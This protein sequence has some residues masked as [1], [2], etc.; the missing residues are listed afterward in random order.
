MRLRAQLWYAGLLFVSLFLITNISLSI[1]THHASANNVA[2]PVAHEVESFSSK[3]DVADAAQHPGVKRLSFL[4]LPSATIGTDVPRK[5]SQQ[6][7]PCSSHNDSYRVLVT[8]LSRSGST[9]QYN[10]IKTILNFELGAVTAVHSDA[11]SLEFEKCLSEQVCVLKTHVFTPRLLP[12]VDF[13][14]TSHRDLRDVLLSSMQMF[15]SCLGTTGLLRSREGSARAHDV[16]Q[17]FQQY[18]HWIP[19]ACYD[20]S[21]ET[22]YADRAAEIVR[23]AAVLGFQRD[24]EYA[25]KVVREIDAAASTATAKKGW[26]AESGFSA[27]HVHQSTTM[28]GAH[29]SSNVLVQVALQLPTCSLG[30]AFRHIEIGFGKWQAEHGYYEDTVTTNA[31]VETLPEYGA[32]HGPR[33]VWPRL[34]HVHF[35]SKGAASSSINLF[36]QAAASAEKSEFIQVSVIHASSCSGSDVVSL[37]DALACAGSPPDYVVVTSDFIGAPRPRLY[38]RIRQILADVRLSP[39]KAFSLP[40][41][42]GTFGDDVWRH[43]ALLLPRRWSSH[44]PFKKVRVGATGWGVGVLTHVQESLGVALVVVDE[45]PFFLN[46]VRGG[47]ELRKKGSSLADLRFQ[48]ELS[49]REDESPFGRCCCHAPV[50]SMRPARWPTQSSAMTSTSRHY[51]YEWLQGVPKE[52]ASHRDIALTRCASLLQSDFFASTSQLRATVDMWCEQVALDQL[53][54]EQLAAHKRRTSTNQENRLLSDAC[55]RESLF[56]GVTPRRIQGVKSGINASSVWGLAEEVETARLPLR[57]VVVR[58]TMLHDSQTAIF[59]GA[60]IRSLQLLDWLCGLGHSVTLV[61]RDGGSTSRSPL[62]KCVVAVKKDA[63]DMR[64]I[65]NGLEETDILVLEVA[66]S[67]RSKILR[68]PSVYAVLER[69]AARGKK[70]HNLRVVVVSYDLHYHAFASDGSSSVRTA[71]ALYAFERQ[72]YASPYVDFVVAASLED[73][74]AFRDLQQLVG[75]VSPGKLPPVVVIPILAKIHSTELVAGH[76]VGAHVASYDKRDTVVFFVESSSS[77][78]AINHIF[79]LWRQRPRQARLVMLKSPSSLSSNWAAPPP[80][81]VDVVSCQ[82]RE[83]IANALRRARLVILVSPLTTCTATAVGAISRGV[84]VL[85]PR[86]ASLGG[87]VDASTGKTRVETTSGNSPFAYYNDDRHFDE[88]FEEAYSDSESWAKRAHAALELAIRLSSSPAWSPDTGELGKIFHHLLDS[89]EEDSTVL[90]RK[91]KRIE[92]RRMRALETSLFH[93]LASR[94]ELLQL[95]SL[96]S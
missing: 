45:E 19:F 69:L 72:I 67:L 82:S 30:R 9:W 73:Q 23:L 66:F 47:E 4:S 32:P 68:K 16:A 58:E 95:A 26:D 62:P 25:Q 77:Q 53:S 18:A 74:R 55:A 2:H 96:N 33:V 60:E 94:I 1:L 61:Y 79:R 3:A 15:G 36:E 39:S 88:I 51:F 57:V 7:R 87:I 59:D 46:D 34:A 41:G 43:H 27:S 37:A 50:Y 63:E 71:A 93:S 22:M 70:R 31:Y 10:A 42:N 91:S 17:R 75:A 92:Q 28:P 38:E 65:D 35:S 5:K 49:S 24:L 80:S 56:K 13:V 81:G 85:A 76:D 20:M 78:A 54:K 40:I 12:S 89:S 29:R 52:A 86:N 11:Y 8:G 84:P 14:F 44:S 21:Y 90:K 48:L 6:M 64:G 83:D